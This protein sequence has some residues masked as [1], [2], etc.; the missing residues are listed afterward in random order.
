MLHLFGNSKKKN[1]C[2]ILDFPK[3]PMLNEEETDIP[4]LPTQQ[5][6]IDTVVKSL[7]T[8]IGQAQLK[9]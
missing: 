4:D 6:E 5:E 3:H 1:L 9:S 7:V 8:K 2:D